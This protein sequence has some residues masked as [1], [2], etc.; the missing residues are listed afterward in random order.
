MLALPLGAVLCWFNLIGARAFARGEV[1]TVL[2]SGG[3]HFYNIAIRS[4]LCKTGFMG[5]CHST[6]MSFR[7]PSFFSYL[8]STLLRLLNPGRLYPS[9]V[10][11][12]SA[13]RTQWSV[14]FLHH[15]CIFLI[16]IFW[17]SSQIPHLT[18]H[19]FISLSSS[20]A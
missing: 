10:Q 12:S 15:C 6:R 14:L 8:L 1:C 17:I 16:L 20:Q 5:H 9:R 2:S 7:V 3:T 19:Y 18:R 11:A 4:S 13:T